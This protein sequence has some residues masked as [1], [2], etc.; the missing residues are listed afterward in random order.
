M[1]EEIKKK[2]LINNK[3]RIVAVYCYEWVTKKNND[4]D[5]YD[6]V[7]GDDFKAKWNFNTTKTLSID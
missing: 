4:K 3:S 7:I 5:V 1:K 6:I 2:N